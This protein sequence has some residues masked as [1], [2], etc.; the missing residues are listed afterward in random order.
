MQR[1]SCSLGFR[2]RSRWTLTLS[3]TKAVRVSP[4]LARSRLA[5][6]MYRERKQGKSGF[7]KPVLDNAITAEYKR[8]GDMREIA[9]ALNVKAEALEELKRCG[10]TVPYKAVDGFRRLLSA[11][12]HTRAN[13]PS[14]MKNVAFQV[15]H[16]KMADEENEGAVVVTIS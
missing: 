2:T 3:L 9:K 7:T 4:S 5:S 11:K 1:L 8:L 10:T 12:L 14:T 15:W 13:V 6:A 16:S